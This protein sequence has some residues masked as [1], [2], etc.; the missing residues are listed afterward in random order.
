VP[1]PTPTDPF[2]RWGPID[3][4]TGVARQF[5]VPQAWLKNQAKLGACLRGEKYDLPGQVSRAIFQG[6]EIRWFAPA[7]KVDVLFYPQLLPAPEE[8]N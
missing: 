7:N 8:T 4:P 5:G 6:G 2:E 3:T 1:Q